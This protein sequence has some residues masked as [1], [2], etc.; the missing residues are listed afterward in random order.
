MPPLV[1]TAIL[2]SPLHASGVF[3]DLE[4]EQADRVV[5]VDPGLLTRNGDLRLGVVDARNIRQ[6]EPSPR[7]SPDDHTVTAWV[8]LRRRADGLGRLQHADV[9]LEIIQ[10]VRSDRRKA[11]VLR[12][13]SN[14]VADR[15]AGQFGLARLDGADAT[16]QFAAAERVNGDK[17][18]S[19][20]ALD[21]RRSFVRPQ[22]V[23]SQM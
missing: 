18:P 23:P 7:A 5:C 15:F 14:G 13:C 21:R 20:L 22:Y 12:G 1:P 10:L 11:W 9:D 17:D 4:S 8:Q 16:P 2:D 3:I 6:Q 19:R